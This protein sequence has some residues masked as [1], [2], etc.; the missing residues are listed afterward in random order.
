MNN[1]ERNTLI[2]LICKR[3]LLRPLSRIKRLAKDPIRAFPFYILAAL[4]HIKP[5]KLSF[6]TLWKSKMTSYLPEGNTF[7]YYGYCEA[8][9]TNFFLRYCEEGKTV[10]DIG[11]HIGFYSALSSVLVGKSGQVHS[12]E[13]T[14]WTYELL[15]E[16]TQGLSNVTTNN[17]AVSEQPTTLTFTDYGH[18]YGA[19]NTASKEGAPALSHKGTVINVQSVSLDEYCKTNSLTPH[20]IKIDAEGFEY[21]ILLGMKELLKNNNGTERPVITLEVAGGDEWKE[22]R[23]NS[24]KALIDNDYIPYEIDVDGHVR[25]HTP[26]KEYTYDNLVF[27]PKESTDHYDHS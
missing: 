6:K 27:I 9:L 5:Y 15:L 3:E 1:E 24:I 10:I 17:K 18:G 4:G 20:F 26:R 22:N 23:D 25:V 11:A 2:G 7:Y 19:Y 21:S 12:F 8:N 13:P 16:N 14:P